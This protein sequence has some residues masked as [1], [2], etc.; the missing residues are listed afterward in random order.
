MHNGERVHPWIP[1]VDVEQ[2]KNAMVLKLDLP[3]MTEKDIT[4]ELEGRTLLIS[5]ERKQDKEAQH[6]GYYSRERVIGR[7]T[8]SFMLPEEIDESKIDAKFR[9]GVLT[10]KIPRPTQQKPRRISI[11]AS[12]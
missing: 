5:G 1:P 9:D 11:K 7:F 2:T 6:E 4:I 12:A 10:V 3:G 8:R